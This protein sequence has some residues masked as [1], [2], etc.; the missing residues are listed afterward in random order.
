LTQN[1][2]NSLSPASVAALEALP[3]P[4]TVTAFVGERAETRAIIRAFVA[5]YQEHKR[6]LALEFVNPDTDPVR[7]REAG[8]RDPAGELVL[9]YGG[10]SENIPLGR[11]S[12]ENMTSALTR[13]GHRGERWLVFL[14][15][16]GERS[17]QG[18]A[19]FDLSTW[20][21][22]LAKRGFHTRPL[23][24]AEDATV[25]DNTTALVIAGPRTRLLE[26]E[27][28]AIEAYVEKGGN[29]LWLMDPGPLHGLE[30]LAERL[31]IE[32]HPGVIVDPASQVLAGNPLALIATQYGAHPTVRDFTQVTLFPE[33]AGLA[34]DPPEGWTSQVLL[35]TR[36]GAWAE[37][38]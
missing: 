7:T 10:T 11:L 32:Q 17:P 30:P 4:V 26:G 6:D 2:L 15:G 37:T 16:H 25:P 18:Q 8:V 34:V 28:K 23:T 5:Q 21:G 29:L 33:T 3:E 22:Q 36:P 1:R 24:L 19:N 35:D 12:E 13:L 38:G 14:A 9:S 20:A 31:G 27:V